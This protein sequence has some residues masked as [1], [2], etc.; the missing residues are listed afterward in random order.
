MAEGNLKGE[1]LIAHSAL[2]HQF[3]RI[4]AALAAANQAVALFERP[5]GSLSSR[6]RENLARALVNRAHLYI[7]RGGWEQAGD[8]AGR[9]AAIYNRL[10]ANGR[11]ELRGSRAQ[12][13]LF[14]AEA[15]MRAGAIAAGLEDYRDGLRTLSDLSQEWAFES[16]I[17]VVYLQRATDAV[18]A[19]VQHGSTEAFN[20]LTELLTKLEEIGTRTENP[21]AITANAHQSLVALNK[22]LP[23][24]G[25]DA[26]SRERLQGLTSH[27]GMPPIGP[28]A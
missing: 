27:C 15:L 1:F 28:D 21:E 7:T 12:A 18:A 19:L 23:D 8:D 6:K 17:L 5:T 25:K 24:I 13:V 11:E 16:D 3:G 26:G 22:L 9:A 14:R 2:L 20:V 10:I 4:P